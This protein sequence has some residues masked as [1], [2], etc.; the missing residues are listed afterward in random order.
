M[1]LS[2]LIKE[3]LDILDLN[4]IFTENCLTHEKIGGHSCKVYSGT[5][6]YFPEECLHCQQENNQTIIKYGWKK[7]MALINDVSEYKTYVR[8]KKQKFLCKSCNRSFLAESTLT[9][10]HCTI[11]RRVKL[12]IA[13]KLK[14]NT[15][16]T[17]IA[18]TKHVSITTIYRVLKDFYTP[19]SQKKKT[20]P[21]VLCFDEF[22]S[23]RASVGAMSFILMDGQTKELL[24]IVENR[25]LNSLK[26]YFYSYA[27]KT[28]AAVQYIV[29]DMYKPYVTLV[30][31]LFP[32]AKLII[33]RFHIVQHSGRTFLTH[34]I[35]QMNQLNRKNYQEE[36][37]YKHLKKYW[38]L[39]QK[40]AWHLEGQKQVWHPSFRVHLTESEV[41][42][43]LLSYS[44]ELKQGYGVYQDFLAAIRTKDSHWFQEL[45]KQNY[46]H[47][48]EKYATTIKTFK[49]YQKGILNAL[50]QPYSNGPLECLNNHIKVLK[51]NAYGFRSFYNFKLRILLTLGT[52]LFNPMKKNKPAEK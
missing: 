42:D 12:S 44:P 28:R 38:K 49:Q 36:Q 2:N 52:T 41:V 8:I 51:R 22:K 9:E 18:R 26:K 30:K 40:N 6:T 20:L 1:S 29:I 14:E 3:T 5:L 21:T 7:V 33:D 11:A 34:R 39:L 13:E 45:L 47:L 15:S 48:P 50:E 24:D 10:R 37:Q 46:S 19:L 16:M 25:K 35:Q 27:Y 31:K 43:R 17:G 4:L 32:N 23:V